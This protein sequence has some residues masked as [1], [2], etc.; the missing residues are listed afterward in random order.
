MGGAVVFT[1]AQFLK[2]NGYSNNYWSYGGEDDDL[3]G[4]SDIFH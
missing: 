4:R 1:K 2:I 3:T